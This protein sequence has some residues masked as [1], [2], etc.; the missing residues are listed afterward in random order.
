M[1][2]DGRSGMSGFDIHHAIEVESN[3]GGGV[4][5]VREEWLLCVIGKRVFWGVSFRHRLR[6]GR[7]G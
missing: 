7:D 5:R 6:E 4:G 1:V 3:G 2:I